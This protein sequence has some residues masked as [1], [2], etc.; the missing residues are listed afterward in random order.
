M[1]DVML[2]NTITGNKIETIPLDQIVD[3]ILVTLATGNESSTAVLNLALPA[4]K[5]TGWRDRFKKLDRSIAI[6]QNTGSSHV[7]HYAG[8]IDKVEATGVSN[9]ALY[10]AVRLSDHA[11]LLK[12]IKLS[13]DKTFTANTW[14][15]IIRALVE[16]AFTQPNTPNITLV[17]GTG[18]GPGVEF[19][20]ESGGSGAS[21]STLIEEVKEASNGGYAEV[22]FSP[23]PLI[24]G[25]NLVGVQ[26]TCVVAAE[27]INL[28]TAVDIENHEDVFEFSISSNSDSNFSRLVIRNAEGEKKTY[29]NPNGGTLTVDEVLEVDA[30]LADFDSIADAFMKSEHLAANESHEVSVKTPIGAV[31]GL[32]GGAG[33]LPKAVEFG[34][35]TSTRLRVVQAEYTISPRLWATPVTSPAESSTAC[36]LT[37]APISNRTW[38]PPSRAAADEANQAR[39]DRNKY[40]GVGRDSYPTRSGNLPSPG[41]G[42]GGGGGGGD[43]PKLPDV[44]EFPADPGWWAGSEG[45]EFPSDAQGRQRPIY[46]FTLSDPQASQPASVAAGTMPGPLDHGQWWNG[47]GMYAGQSHKGDKVLWTFWSSSDPRAFAH[48]NVSGRGQQQWGNRDYGVTIP[49]TP[50][51]V[52]RENVPMHVDPLTDLKLVVCEATLSEGEFVNARRVSE[53]VFTADQQKELTLGLFMV[54]TQDDFENLVRL[55]LEDGKIDNDEEFRRDRA[56]IIVSIVG[57]FTTEDRIVML[58]ET[59]IDVSGSNRVW[60]NVVRTLNVTKT[61]DGEW[62]YSPTSRVISTGG[63]IRLWEQ[64]IQGANGVPMGAPQFFSESFR[65]GDTWF[66]VVSPTLLYSAEDTS[67]AGLVFNAYHRNSIDPGSYNLIPSLGDLST[68]GTTSKAKM[69]VARSVKGEGMSLFALVAGQYS[70]APLYELPL[71]DGMLAART[72]NQKWVEATMYPD[73]ILAQVSG[74]SEYSKSLTVGGAVVVTGGAGS[75]GGESMRRI[76][77]TYPQRTEPALVRDASRVWT[78]TGTSTSDN[79]NSP[80]DF[81]TFNVTTAGAETPS[82]EFSDLYQAHFAN[83][84][85]YANRGAFYHK[86]YIYCIAFATGD[87]NNYNNVRIMSTPGAEDYPFPWYSAKM[88]PRSEPYQLPS[89]GAYLPTAFKKMYNDIPLNGGARMKPFNPGEPR[90]ETRDKV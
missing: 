60:L 84:K 28:A 42:G 51:Y 35:S 65:A 23:K 34:W 83:W 14:G 43:T 31:R 75:G 78:D 61:G 12:M 32:V 85:S 2:Y 38:V 29:T 33:V 48:S 10:L 66:G 40:S 9:G 57:L 56:S 41:S 37:F 13:E 5:V 24:V 39:I 54:G 58:Y 76:M 17:G 82:G 71:K 79:G 63:G 45:L 87:S 80:N 81:I 50:G 86:G 15:G 3:D 72:A 6:T 77:L 25:G 21:Y 22:A 67:A 68:A 59:S 49:T 36:V 74:A 88:T 73:K 19:A 20:A 89:E 30:A 64:A 47:R 7:V 46:G 11:E 16:E 8:F 52:D 90:Y 27:L 44:P 1:L 70:T 26:W 55:G 69:T 4:D 18:T 62:D 53:I